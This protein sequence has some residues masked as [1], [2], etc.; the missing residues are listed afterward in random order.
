MDWFFSLPLFWQIVGV[1]IAAT[2]L[3]VA[4]CCALAYG[5]GLSIGS[6][7]RRFKP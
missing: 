5:M 2:V 7:T 1:F 6:I 3:W 4:W